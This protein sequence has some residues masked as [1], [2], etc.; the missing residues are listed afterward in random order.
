MSRKHKIAAHLSAGDLIRP[1]KKEAVHV[2]LDVTPLVWGSFMAVKLKSLF[3]ESEETQIFHW[4]SH[5]ALYKI[6]ERC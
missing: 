6:Q 1:D 2:V 4:T 5:F 3:D